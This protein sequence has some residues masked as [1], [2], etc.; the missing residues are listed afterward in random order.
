MVIVIIIVA[1]V[2]LLIGFEMMLV[3]GVPAFLIKEVFFGQVPDAVL[4]Q[5]LVGGVNHTTLLA[6]PFF[7]FAAELMASGEIAKRL[8]NLI[9]AAF[10]HRAGGIGHTTIGGSMAFG[11]V[12][13]SAPATVAAL[14]RLMYPELRKAGYDEKFSL[15]LIV[16]SA[17]T[18]LLIPPASR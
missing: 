9:K 1:I 13:G 16:S 18:A 5:K 3:L 8:T 11:S 14:G 17:E 2:M 10:G 4:I 15:G 7:V 12:S 6:I